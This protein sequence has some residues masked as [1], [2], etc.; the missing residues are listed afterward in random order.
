MQYTHSRSNTV[1][2]NQ[3]GTNAGLTPGS[4]DGTWGRNGVKASYRGVYVLAVFVGW[5]PI[6]RLPAS[7]RRGP[8]WMYVFGFFVSGAGTNGPSD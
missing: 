2:H 4:T 6:C 5:S 7:E 3:G 1:P 8:L